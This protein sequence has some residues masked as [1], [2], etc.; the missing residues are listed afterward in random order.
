MSHERQ[1]VTF[2][3]AQ[4]VPDFVRQWLEGC[5]WRFSFKHQDSQV[6]KKSDANSK[7]QQI[8]NT[9]NSG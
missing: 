2:P 3:N 7:T 5:L 4:F 8:G 1:E 9:H 6:I